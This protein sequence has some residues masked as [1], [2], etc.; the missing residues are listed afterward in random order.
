VLLVTGAVVAAGAL[1]WWATTSVVRE[2]DDARSAVASLQLAARSRAALAQDPELALALAAEAASVPGAPSDSTAALLDA[3]RVVAAPTWQPV[4]ATI[5]AHPG[6]ATAIAYSP[7]GTTLLV[8][9]FDER[10]RGRA[11]AWDLTTNEVLATL[12]GF[13]GPLSAVAF[14]PDGALAAIG[15]AD[16]LVRI[17]DTSS[18]QEAGRS[19]GTRGNRITAVAFSPD[20]TLLAV[21]GSQDD[22]AGYLQ[23]WDVATRNP[24]GDPQTDIAPL[25]CLAWHPDGTRLALCGTD[26]QGSDGAVQL[27]DAATRRPVGAPLAGHYGEVSS[28]AFNPAGD[29]LAS[30]GADGT[31]RV[32]DPATGAPV[33]SPIAAHEER[34]TAVAFRPDGS[35][36]ASSGDDATV[37][38]WRVRS[39]DPI[40][41]PLVSQPGGVAGIGW[42]PDGQQ[43][44]AAN[45][46]GTVQLWEAT[47][48]DPLGRPLPGRAAG[49]ALPGAEGGVLSIGFTPEGALVT[50]G[51]DADRNLSVAQV[52]DPTTG[53]PLGEP[54]QVGRS[55]DIA[56]SPDGT[57]L[58]AG[59]PT[60]AGRGALQ[61]WRL[62]DGEPVGAP[63]TGHDGL[64][65]RVSFSP[66]GRLVASAAMNA[67]T[68]EATV[69]IWDAQTR[70]LVAEQAD[71]PPGRI[72]GMTFSPD[73]TLLALAVAN[74][75]DWGVAQLLDT[76]SGALVGDPLLSDDE[77]VTAVAFTPDG[78]QLVT[79][80]Q[81]GTLTRWDIATRT[82][83]A[84][85]PT[86]RD[87]PVTGIT[88][89]PDGA[90]MATTG[91][92][93]ALR[94]WDAATGQQLGEPLNN[95]PLA[96]LSFNRDG[97]LL[98]TAGRDGV[99]RLWDAWRAEPACDLVRPLV[100]RAEV[101]RVA[102][103]EWTTSACELP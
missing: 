68:K 102:P 62:P 31:I 29:R 59:A 80:G 70:A 100:S 54:L 4:E 28:V 82:A 101:A 60:E 92:L 58:V 8:T 83:L 96:G 69:R 23:L 95:G 47:S 25:T 61:M 94:F 67:R 51:A 89:S 97:T 24:L 20:G 76:G 79:G 39:G 91:G 2:R 84:E 72:R 1:A 26:P 18:W 27:W 98:A 40:G 56:L 10:D 7:D 19:V 36:L 75:Q 55:S 93:G 48:G 45:R 37:R 63:M 99:V 73:S 38:L 52:W 65:T 88:F 22:A 103:Q 90:L 12:D 77:E 64:V 32:W 33:G 49:Q 57:L 44:A 21:G 66:D 14:S 11:Q 30:A 13:A 17:W 6:G 35:V 71:L 50:S 34:V 74:P 9:G 3:R 46:D 16:G 42:R 5:E 53:S 85:S 15:G 87:V 81:R 86:D 41:A 78:R 43:L